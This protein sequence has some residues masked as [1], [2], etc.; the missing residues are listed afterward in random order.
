MNS[1]T[2][3][4]EQLDAAK[5]VL[6]AD[7]EK[8]ELT[9]RSCIETLTQKND[10][11]LLADA[12]YL[13]GQITFNRGKK[14]EAAEAIKK[15]VTLREVTGESAKLSASLNTLG[16]ILTQSGDYTTALESCFKSLRIKEDLND[17]K[18]IAGV[19]INI[20]SIY[21][22]LNNDEQEI[23]MYERSLQIAEEIDDRKLIAYNELNLG[24][25]LANRMDFD[26]ALKY[27][28]GL[29]EIFLSFG[30]KRNAVNAL[31]NHGLIFSKLQQFDKAIACYEHCMK[32]SEETGNT[33]GIVNSFMNMG[34]ALLRM[35]KTNEAKNNIDEALKLAEQHSLKTG[36][37]DVRHIRYEYYNTTGN[38][39]QAL[40]EFQQ[41]ISI[42]DELL[43]IQNL[44]QLGELHLKYDLEKKEKEAEINYLKNVELKD[45]LNKLQV[46]KDRSERLLLN[47]LPEE[48]AEELKATGSAKAKYFEQVSV[49]FIDIKN[50]TIIS[51]RLSPEEL[52]AEID[53][54]FRHFDEIIARYDI[55][56][57]KTIG[58]AYMCASGIPV[59]N[60]LH[61][62]NMSFAALEILSFM[63]K[64][65]AHSE[66]N[67]KPYFEVRIG[68]HSGPVVAGIVGSSKFAYDIWGDTVNT[69]ARM[70]QT[71]E[72]GQINISGNTYALIKNGFN[73]VYRGKIAAKNKGEI[74]MYFLTQTTVS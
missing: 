5:A 41:Y 68:I 48:V 37:K 39:K 14:I 36:I 66:K 49:M 6:T 71:G 35:G 67:D 28:N 29:A 57:I 18:G 26:K 19:L 47:I 61:A 50:F 25:L 38:Y 53:F 16:V 56:K 62:A 65:K 32:L 22:R 12:Y 10:T 74:D 20:G 60:S 9:C 54:L 23:K 64:L 70:E 13:L 43:N 2:Y 4:R 44:K 45:A 42:K 63:N 7:P 52:V 46:E 51:E 72:V 31:N 59:S 73:C 30:D 1:N 34:E 58:D 33:A 69:A 11:S 21:Q 8:A 15:T 24:L 27:M 3:I 17:K 40:E 55:E